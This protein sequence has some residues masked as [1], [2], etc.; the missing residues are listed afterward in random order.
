MR[1]T[2]HQDDKL[3]HSI[4]NSRGWERWDLA[5][6]ERHAP[7]KGDAA[8]QLQP[9]IAMREGPNVLHYL[10]FKRSQKFRFIL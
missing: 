10:S 9:G 3:F 8:T 7:S 4:G 6:L 2:S 1:T 5:Q